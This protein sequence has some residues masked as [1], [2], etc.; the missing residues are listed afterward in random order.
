M[1]TSLSGLAGAS[2][3]WTVSVGV[4]VKVDTLQREVGPPLFLDVVVDTSDV[5]RCGRVDTLQRE[6]GPPL[7]LDVVIAT[8]DVRRSCVYM[9]QG[10]L[11]LTS[12]CS[13]GR[14]ALSS[15]LGV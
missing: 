13:P 9:L 15:V 11:V 1:I 8:P 3:L 10:C 12:T 6:V 5:R 14:R 4:G 7:F 2:P